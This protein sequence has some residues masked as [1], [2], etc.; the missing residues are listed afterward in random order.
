MGKMK[1][2]K[3]RIASEGQTIDGRKITRDQITQMGSNYNREGKY[4]ARVWQEHFRGLIDSEFSP[5]NAHGDVLSTE[6]KEEDGKAVLYGD[7]EPLPS[8]IKMNERG[9]KIFFSIEMD[10]DFAGTGEA[11]LVGLAVT[12]SPASTG[13]EPMKFSALKTEEKIM[14]SSFAEAELELFEEEE[15]PTLLEQVK[16]M[17][18]RQKTTSD[19]D[20]DAFSKDVKGAV[21]AIA[22][23]VVKLS[24]KE[25]DLSGYVPEAKFNELQTKFGELETAHDD[26]VKQLE[27]ETSQH[28]TSRPP[29]S[30]GD[31]D[32]AKTDC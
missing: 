17:L 24:G 8:L 12:D 18:S 3:F 31:G 13:T 15:K 6:W 32:V 10:P 2:K 22:D 11:Y 19:A 9:Q 20:F 25:A 21:E 5:F 14:F 29:A 23:E 1:S 16:T 28:H 7:V 26:L 27:G 4:G 30:G